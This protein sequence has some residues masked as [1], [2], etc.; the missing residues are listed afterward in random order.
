[1]AEPE[2]Q[3]LTDEAFHAVWG[4]PAGNVFAVGG[5]FDRAITTDG[6]R[7]TRAP[8]KFLYAVSEL[9]VVRRSPTC[10]RT[11]FDGVVADS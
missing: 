4:D 3:S 6:V 2:P 11:M 5:E 9:T 8:Q 7:S 1:M 10:E